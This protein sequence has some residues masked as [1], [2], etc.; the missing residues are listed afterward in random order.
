MPDLL[1]WFGGLSPFRGP[2]ASENALRGRL[3]ERCGRLQVR[4]ADYTDYTDY[5]DGEVLAEIRIC[6]ICVIVV[7]SHR[8]STM[9]VPGHCH[10]C[11]AD[12]R[13]VC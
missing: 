7:A 9:L 10:T 4:S 11:A 3:T 5:T 13:L 12:Y 8:T 1:N 6:V 2:E